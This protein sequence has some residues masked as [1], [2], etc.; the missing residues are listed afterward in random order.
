[1]DVRYHISDVI[2]GQYITLKSTPMTLSN[3]FCF[4]VGLARILFAVYSDRPA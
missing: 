4:G 1:M 2:S 3:I